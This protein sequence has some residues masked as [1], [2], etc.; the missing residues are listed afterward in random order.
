[1]PHL[2]GM[3]TSSLDVIVRGVEREHGLTPENAVA[4]LTARAHNTQLP[5]CTRDELGEGDETQR[6]HL[7]HSS[8]HRVLVIHP[9][10]FGWAAL[11]RKAILVW[12][13][14]A[15]LCRVGVLGA[16]LSLASPL[17]APLPLEV[18]RPQLRVPPVHPPAIHV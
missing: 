11:C 18:H 6:L 13:S 4:D 8:S 10:Q 17:A 15:E 7:G 1:M 16:V 3:T 12:K 14:Y 5:K 2:A 9:M